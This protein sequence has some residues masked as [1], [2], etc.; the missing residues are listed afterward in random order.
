MSAVNNTETPGTATVKYKHIA[1][2]SNIKYQDWDAN[3]LK[4]FSEIA[5]LIKLQHSQQ[6]RQL[7]EENY[8]KHVQNKHNRKYCIITPTPSESTDLYIAYNDLS[9]DED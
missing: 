4:E 7:I 1:S 9:S 6:Y 8:K 5:T 2:R 3:G